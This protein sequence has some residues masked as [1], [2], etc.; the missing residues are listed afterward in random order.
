MNKQSVI[1]RLQEIKNYIGNPEPHV[2]FNIFV[3]E[4]PTFV[5]LS[6]RRKLIIKQLEDEV[7]RLKN[8]RRDLSRDIDMLNTTIQIKQNQL[9]KIGED[10]DQLLVD[11]NSAE[12]PF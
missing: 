5:Y 12:L 4:Y 11:I 3:P 7:K 10:I 6:K 2:Y 9:I 1:K 8:Y